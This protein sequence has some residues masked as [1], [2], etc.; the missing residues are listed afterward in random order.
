MRSGS[1]ELMSMSMSPLA[2]TLLGLS[3]ITVL[4]LMYTEGRGGC[5]R[6]RIGRVVISDVITFRIQWELVHKRD[7]DIESAVIKIAIIRVLTA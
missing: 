3:S 2:L 7:R 4:A 6:T 5:I 1:S